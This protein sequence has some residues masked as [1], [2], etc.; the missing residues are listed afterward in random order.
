VKDTP[1]TASR[2]AELTVIRQTPRRHR[3]Q[4]PKYVVLVVGW[5]RLDGV[6]VEV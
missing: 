3:R 2:R 1:S 6:V 5:N 4:S